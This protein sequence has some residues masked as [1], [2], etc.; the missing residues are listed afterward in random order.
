MF[1]ATD[2]MSRLFSPYD[3]NPQETIRSQ[4]LARDHVLDEFRCTHSALTDC[5]VQV[6][7]MFP[8]ATVEEMN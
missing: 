7:G 5:K 2:M 8:N 4:G 1:V 6:V 3:L